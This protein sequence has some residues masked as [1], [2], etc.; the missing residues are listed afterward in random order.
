[1]R[2]DRVRW[3]DEHIFSDRIN[4]ALL[5]RV[6]IF[7]LIDTRAIQNDGKEARRGEREKKKERNF[8]SGAMQV[9]DGD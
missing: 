9:R 7:Y 8:I 6:Q 2:D 4:L 5:L 3:V 1:M